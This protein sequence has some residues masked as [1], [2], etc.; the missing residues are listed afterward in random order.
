LYLGGF[1]DEAPDLL[2]EW[3]ERPLLSG[4]ALPGYGEE[5]VVKQETARR[6]YLFSGSHREMG[7]L[8]AAGSAFRKGTEL[9]EATLLDIAP[10]LLHLLDQ[11]IPTS[12]DGQLLYQAL[13]PGCLQRYPAR[14]VD[15]SGALSAAPGLALSSAEEDEVIGR[16]RALGYVD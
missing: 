12:L 4:L 3:A 5:V 2:V 9:G 11:P 14:Y 10:T 6:R 16:L 13:A 8:V 1:V 7:I 15:E